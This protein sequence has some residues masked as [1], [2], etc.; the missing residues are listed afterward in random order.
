MNIRC[1]VFLLL[2]A[3]FSI[4]VADSTVAGTM[5]LIPSGTFDMGSTN[6]AKDERP[7]HRVQ[8]DSFYI[9]ATDVTIWEYLK[10]VQSGKCRMPYWW[11]E[12]FLSQKADKLSGV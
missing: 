4:K 8:V 12:R 3:I 7:V 6:G 9:G 1:I 2:L 10:C 5:V 11:N